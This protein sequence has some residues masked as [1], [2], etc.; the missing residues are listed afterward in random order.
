MSNA[1]IV[2]IRVGP[3][4]TVTSDLV[5]EA[6]NQNAACEQILTLMN[7]LGPVTEHDQRCGDDQPV[8]INLGIPGVPEV[9]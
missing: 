8:N 2:E 3:K 1:A 7:S 6:A 9:N 4:G 5:Q